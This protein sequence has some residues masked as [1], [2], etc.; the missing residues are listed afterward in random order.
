MRRLIR[1]ILDSRLLR[2]ERGG[3]AIMMLLAF[4]VLAVPIAASASKTSSQLALNSR[5]Y[6]TRLTG[7]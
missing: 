5:V 6:D 4:M 3:I 7:F 1:G 2:G